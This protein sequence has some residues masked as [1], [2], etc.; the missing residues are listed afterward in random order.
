MRRC[1]EDDDD[2]GDDEKSF[3]SSREVLFYYALLSR[4]KSSKWKIFLADIRIHVSSKNR[5]TTTKPSLR[6]SLAPIHSCIYLAQTKRASLF[7]GAEEQG[8]L[9]Y[10]IDPLILC[11]SIIPLSLLVIYTSFTFPY[12][13]TISTCALHYQPCSEKKK[14]VMLVAQTKRSSSGRGW[15]QWLNGISRTSNGNRHTKVKTLFVFPF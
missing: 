1:E 14:I 8:G 5:A 15:W 3:F 9:I 4:Y 6:I 2:D 7:S 12:I 13:H 11:T 10:I